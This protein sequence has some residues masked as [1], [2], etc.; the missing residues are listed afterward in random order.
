MTRYVGDTATSLNQDSIESIWERRSLARKY[1]QV[2]SK[3]KF[4]KV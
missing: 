1:S 2:H 3:N 4:D